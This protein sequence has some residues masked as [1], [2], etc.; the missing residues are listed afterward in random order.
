MSHH[1]VVPV[2]VAGPYRRQTFIPSRVEI[3]PDVG[4]SF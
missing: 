2:L 4:L 1:V 3:L